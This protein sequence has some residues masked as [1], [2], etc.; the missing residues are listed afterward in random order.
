[1]HWV[2]RFASDGLTFS[3]SNAGGSGL[4]WD[5]S[6]FEHKRIDLF[7]TP[8]KREALKVEDASFPGMKRKSRSVIFFLCRKSPPQPLPK[9][10]SGGR[11]GRGHAPHEVPRRR[12][13]YGRALLLSPADGPGRGGGA[14][15]SL[16]CHFPLVL[17]S[18]SFQ[19]HPLS[20]SSKTPTARPRR[21]LF[22]RK[23]ALRPLDGDRHASPHQRGTRRRR[24]PGL[25]ASRRGAP[26]RRG[27]AGRAVPVGRGKPRVRGAAGGG[28]AA[29][30]AEEQ[31]Q[32]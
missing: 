8:A 22:A 11:Q 23:P 25:G 32:R 2:H 18:S 21:P 20:P 1:M 10:N 9:K 26:C 24:S 28:R 31:Q 4:L 14:G 17:P 3:C 29:D 5:H 16:V 12:A 30:E 13:A 6:I 7:C 19:S 27:A 15:K